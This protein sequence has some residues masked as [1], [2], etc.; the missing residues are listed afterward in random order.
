MRRGRLAAQPSQLVCEAV[1]GLMSDAQCMRFNLR[2]SSFTLPP[3]SSAVIALA[4]A[5]VWLMIDRI[6]VV[7]VVVVVVNLGVISISSFSPCLV[8]VHSFG[9]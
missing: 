4:A 1:T 9:C 3:A 2:R 7:V 6:E 5:A 8:V